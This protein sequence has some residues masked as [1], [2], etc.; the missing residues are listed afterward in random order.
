[1]QELGRHLVYLTT[2][3]DCFPN[4]TVSILEQ[5]YLQG[6]SVVPVP[7][8]PGDWLES[9]HSQSPALGHLNQTLCGWSQIAK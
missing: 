6:I 7:A 1:M 4:V 3:L 8:P 9:V 2:P 5:R